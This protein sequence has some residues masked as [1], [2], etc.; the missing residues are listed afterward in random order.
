MKFELGEIGVI[1]PNENDAK[2]REFNI[3]TD[4]EFLQFDFIDKTDKSGGFT[5]DVDQVKLLIDTL[6]LILKNKL[7]K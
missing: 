7:I 3:R 5:L 6:N 4:G 1:Y 2:H